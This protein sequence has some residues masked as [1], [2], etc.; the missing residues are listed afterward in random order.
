MRELS[1]RERKLRNRIILILFMLPFISLISASAHLNDLAKV[2]AKGQL[3]MLT[4]P[5][6]TTYFEDGHGK[7]GFDYLLAK[8]F[9]DSLGVEL[10]VKTK[11]TLRRLL[12]SIGGPQ[13]DFAAA[14]LVVTAARNQSLVFGTPYLEVTQQLIY[15]RSSKRPKSLDSLDDELVVIAD[16]SHS[17]HLR[18]LQTEHPKLSWIEQDQ[19]EMSDL[20]R[21]VHEGEIS[22]SVVDSIAYLINRHIYPKARS[23]MDISE[24]QPMAWA[25]PAHHDGTLLDAA[26]TFLQ[27]YIESGELEAL[28]SQLLAQTEN[29]SVSNSQRLGKLVAQRLP[30]YEPL[31]RET[32]AKY[33]MDWRLLAAV[34]Y[35]ESHWNPR[36]KS[37][38]GVRGLMMLTLNT[39][40]EMQ[41]TNRLD[42]AQSLQGGAAYFIKLKRRLP[43]RIMDPDRTLFALAA[44][45][46][47]FGHLED[48]RILTQRSG[49]NPDS[50]ADVREHLPL[51]SKKKYYSTLKHGYARGNEPVLYVDNIQ[52][53][54]TY[55]QLH[56]L[57]Q[58]DFMPQPDEQR[59]LQDWEIKG[60][61]SL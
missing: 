50:W 41:V 4:L 49:K 48:A 8:A 23:A 42:A 61:P 16:S 28:T 31:F 26:N 1:N 25:F 6:P 55:L 56:S 12:Y 37:P 33:N 32:A 34:A 52:Y 3:V 53:Y 15:H 39:A 45:N 47:G 44:Y 9:A 27:H 21:R 38:T 54:K 14:N 20:I 35:Q 7:N 59:E 30:K 43:S 11:S 22:Y 2:R 17:E 40:R 19:A 51:L 24:P 5:G 13:G 60:L 58:Q 18:N 29:F 36:A 57:S 46:V 10:V